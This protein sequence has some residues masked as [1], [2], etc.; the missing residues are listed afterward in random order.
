[1]VNCSDGTTEDTENAESTEN[2]MVNCSDGTTEDT[3]DTE[4]KGVNCGKREPQRTL[5]TRS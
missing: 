3:E 2:K 1:M 4:D 5:R